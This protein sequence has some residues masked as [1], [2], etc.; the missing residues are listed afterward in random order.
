MLCTIF[1]Y[2]LIHTIKPLIR[3]LCSLVPFQKLLNSV[4]DNNFIFEISLKGN[5]AAI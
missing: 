4:I 2:S 5:E 3:S 1:S